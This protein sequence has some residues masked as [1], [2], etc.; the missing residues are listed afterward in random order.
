MHLINFCLEPFVQHVECGCVCADEQSLHNLISTNPHLR[1]RGCRVEH[2]IRPPVHLE[3]QF[4]A[5][6]HVACILIRP[7]L[8]ENAEA[9][10]EI[11]GSLNSPSSEG[12][13]Y[14]PCGS[15][16]MWRSCDGHVNTDNQLTQIMWQSCDLVYYYYC[17]LVLRN[18]DTVHWLFKFAHMHTNN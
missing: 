16:L 10:I 11:A 17:V 3:F 12:H 9:R 15:S 8:T 5:P 2:F 7:S 14:K 13:Y 18:K 1:T 6:V 4:S